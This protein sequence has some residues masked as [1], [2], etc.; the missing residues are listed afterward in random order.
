MARPGRRFGSCCSSLKDALESEQFNRL[1]HVSEDGILFMSIGYTKV[2]GDRTGWF[3]R[4]VLYCP[5]CGTQ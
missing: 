3:D 5:F 1:M 2:P 4:T